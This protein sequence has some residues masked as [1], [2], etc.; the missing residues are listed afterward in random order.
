[1]RKLVL[2]ESHL[3]AITQNKHQNFETQTLSSISLLY[4]YVLNVCAMTYV[5]VRYR[6][7][8]EMLGNYCVIEIC[9]RNKYSREVY[10]GL[11]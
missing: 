4:I 10:I 6:F 5:V 2:R 8:L 1:M 3:L 7:V 11:A 9:H